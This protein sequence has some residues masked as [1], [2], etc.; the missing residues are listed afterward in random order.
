MRSMR[1]SLAAALVGA[2][3]LAAGCGGSGSSSKS[4][5]NTLPD[6]ASLAPKDA[7]VWVSVDTDRTSDQWKALDA[8]LTQIPGAE[9]LVDDALAQ[10]GSG[11]KKLDFRRDVQPALGKE[12]V[13][14]L[15]AGSS[16]PVLLAKPSDNAKFKALLHN[17][18]KPPVTGEHDGWTVVAQTQKALDAYQA[19]LDKGTLADSDTF[20]QAMD[21]LPQVALARV[22]VDGKG[23]GGAFGKAAG[24]ASG[25]LQSLPI[26][27]AGGLVEGLNSK[28]LEQFGTIGLAVSAGDH[29]LRVDGSVETAN[30]VHPV[31]YAPTLLG[32]VPAD[33]LVAVSWN[34]S[35]AVTSLLQ[36]GLGE[37]KTLERQLGVTQT[38]LAAA[39]DGEGV[40]YLRPSLLIPEV[41]L[42]IRPN[43]LARAKRVFED[44]AEK[45]RRGASGTIS[46]PGL[47]P[48]V[49]TVGDAVLV[50]T[51]KDVTASFGGSGTRLTD[52][53]R[54]KT[55]ASDV[56]LGAKTGGFVYVDV[57]ALGPL[58]NAVLSAAGSGSSP[59]ASLEQLTDV[60]SA[61][62]FVA[63]DSSVD[64]SRVHFEGVVRVG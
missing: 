27:S 46:I 51:A 64:G 59:D 61:I 34:G 40:L 21:G 6:T 19:A 14:V 41:T 49:S 11:D 60:L 63:L 37:T 9:K 8:V 15:P 2:A 10:I 48:T 36:A 31:L 13:I 5:V 4:S 32:K 57:K 7:A 24:V 43:D 29:V 45:T 42:A 62:D 38:D 35:G 22:Y 1:G 44:I 47:E 30:G 56:G 16:D 50:S 12:V 53:D 3:L 20:A 52:S 23:L 33:A 18:T 28:A 17:S 25:A 55:A 26:S 58:V 54:F 39:L